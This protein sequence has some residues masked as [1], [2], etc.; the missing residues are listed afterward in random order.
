M[1]DISMKYPH[2][3]K[4]KTRHKHVDAGNN[5]RKRKWMNVIQRN[6]IS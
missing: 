3:D 6:R 2:R 4:H 1:N 5:L